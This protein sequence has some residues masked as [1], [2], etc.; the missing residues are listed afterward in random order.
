MPDK[1]INKLQ[2]ARAP[3][4]ACSVNSLQCKGSTLQNSL[5]FKL[6]QYPKIGSGQ[7]EVT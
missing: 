6:R 7:F 4:V 3:A 5:N 1:L 2:L